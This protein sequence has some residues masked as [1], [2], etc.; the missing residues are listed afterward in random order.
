V[1]IFE[2]PE[3]GGLYRLKVKQFAPVA[4]EVAGD[5]GEAG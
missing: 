5:S 4:V 1:V 2:I 3:R